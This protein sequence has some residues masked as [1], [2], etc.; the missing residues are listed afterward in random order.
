MNDLLT[1]KQA[2]RAIQVSESSIKRWCDSGLIKAQ[3]TAGRHRR[4]ATGAMIE[5]LRS[6]QYDLIHPEAIGM[7][8]GTRR[9]RELGEPTSRQLAEALI[10]GDEDLCRQIV[11]GLYL[12]EKSISAICDEV[13]AQSLFTIGKQWECGVARVYEERRGCEIALRL[14]HELRL[15]LP[16]PPADA[17]VAIGG[18]VEGDQF[19]LATA[20]VELVLRDAKWNATSLGNNLPFDTLATA[21]NESRPKVFWLSCSH[22]VD[23]GSFL[24]GHGELYDEFGLDVAFAVGGRALTGELRQRMKY[25]AFC[26]NMRHLEAFAQTI[27]KSS[28]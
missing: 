16:K 9:L 1:P 15:L 19:G 13:L 18:T 23:E 14:L 8:A 27:Q 25:A 17:P 26:D 20:I 4:I 12:A 28:Q 6:S 2:G 24:K 21:I 3:Y 5:F 22:I 10:R 7:P 11:L